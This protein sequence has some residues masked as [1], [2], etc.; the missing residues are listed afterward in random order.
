MNWRDFHK[1]LLRFK[2]RALA[3]LIMLG[4]AAAAWIGWDLPETGHLA[5]RKTNL[6]I[7]IRDWQG[8]EHPFTLGPKNHRW[9]PLKAVPEALKWSV[10]AAEDANFYS[11]QGIDVQALKEALKYDLEQ[12]RLARGASTIT[13]QLAKNL[14]LSREKTLLRKMKEFLI[15]RRM[16]QELSKGRILE[17]YLN[18]V[19]LGP[20][21]FG[22]GHGASYYFG[23][24]VSQLTPGECAFL[25]AM[26]PGPRVAYNPYRNLG[27]VE[28]RAEH[29][30]K[31]LKIRG[32]L[33]EA[34]YRL[35]LADKP[36]IPGLQR[37]PRQAPA[38]PPAE[39]PQADAEETVEELQAPAEAP[40]PMVPPDE[41]EAEEE[42][43]ALP[44][45][46]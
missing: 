29:I 20:M 32:V 17:L 43:Q 18:V 39:E 8:Q 10:I 42:S 37:R 3:L 35:A 33:S 38:A 15:A 24:Q 34:E 11:H 16:E 45:Q 41:P 7:Q 31:L 23:K 46:S 28:K 25:V 13:Q 2:L 44:P 12:K 30:L 27:R 19:E 9:T 26:L 40:V 14:F 21:V 36:D 5:D 4:T 1:G 22:V 6:V